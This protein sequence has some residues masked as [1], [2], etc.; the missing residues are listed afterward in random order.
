MEQEQILE[1][2]RVSIGETGFTI[3]STKGVHTYSWVN[4]GEIHRFHGLLLVSTKSHTMQFNVLNCLESVRTLMQYLEGSGLAGESNLSE[5]EQELLFMY[6]NVTT[7]D[8]NH[9][10][11]VCNTFFNRIN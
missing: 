7:D 8:R 1:A 4:V 11:E 6:R 9:L 3:T 5:R 2:K 10:F